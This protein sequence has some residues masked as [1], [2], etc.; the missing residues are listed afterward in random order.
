MWT[1]SSF[2]KALIRMVPGPSIASVAFCNRAH[3]NLIQLSRET[4]H[5]GD[6]VE[7][8]DHHDS[9]FQRAL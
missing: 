8:F 2:V 1:K 5:L 6:L 7:F 4:Q 9:I 3:E